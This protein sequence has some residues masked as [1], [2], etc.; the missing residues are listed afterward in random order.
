M[1]FE[2]PG[3]AFTVM[4]QLGSILAIVWLYRRKILDVITGLRTDADARRFAV[5][6]IVAFIPAAVV[7]GLFGSYVKTVLY[8]SPRVFAV[9]FIVGGI[10]ILLVERFRP[11][12]TVLD[13]ER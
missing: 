6:I 8:E 4:I 10:V 5:M 1:R 13:A 2:D 3:G 9:A 12:P 11:R 7:A